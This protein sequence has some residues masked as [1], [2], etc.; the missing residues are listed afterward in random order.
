MDMMLIA[1]IEYRS[2]ADC[3][4]FGAENNRW[5][6]RRMGDEIVDETRE[7]EIKIILKLLFLD[8]DT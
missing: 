5:K 4:K 1:A 3:E 8:N 7:R 2:N 6:L